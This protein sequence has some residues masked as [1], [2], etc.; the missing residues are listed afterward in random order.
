MRE[1]FDPCQAHDPRPAHRTQKQSPP[2]TKWPFVFDRHAMSMDYSSWQEVQKNEVVRKRLAKRIVRECFRDGEFENFHASATELNDDAVQA[3]MTDAV[4]RTHVF[5]S[6][7][8]NAMG[9][10]IVERLKEQDD[11]PGWDDPE[12]VHLFG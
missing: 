12:D 6:K 9:D 4:N 3:I 8:S 2:R 10:L 5:L 1:H 7:L 11:V